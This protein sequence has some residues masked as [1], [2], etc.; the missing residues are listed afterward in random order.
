MRRLH[1]LVGIIFR[2]AANTL[3][4]AV[5]SVLEQDSAGIRV[6][7]LL[8]DDSSTDDWHGALGERLGIR[9]VHVRRVEVRSAAKARNFVL[10]EVERA[11]PDV[12]YVC[13]L[14][15]DDVLA[16]PGVLTEVAGLLRR[17][18][19]DALLAGNMQKRDGV[20]LPLP[21]LAS[22]ELLESEQ[23]L[24][25]LARMAKGDPSAELPSCNTVVRRGLPLRYPVV[26]SA[27]DHWFT[28]ALLLGSARVV[29]APGLI[30][31]VYRLR[32]GLTVRNEATDAY[33][34]SRR[35]LLAFARDHVRDEVLHGSG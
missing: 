18:Q 12:D 1:L 21:N 14:D 6:S 22:P 16:G 29:V 2:D 15:A 8:V 20:L 3:A 31:A 24:D 13:R 34:A 27:E 25:R 9:D 33:L 35:A 32:G 4:A 17:E 11:F 19:P 23:L 30:Y 5:D 10:D 26:T 28:T 7:V